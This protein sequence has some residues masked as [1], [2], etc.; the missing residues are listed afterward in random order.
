MERGTKCGHTWQ[1]TSRI[2]VKVQPV[3]VIASPARPAPT[4]EVA[5]RQSWLSGRPAAL[6]LAVALLAL[7]AATRLYDLRSLPIFFD[8]AHYTLSAL[9]I[10]RDPLHA[11][12]FTEVAHWGVPPLFT[13]L[14]APLAALL[15]DPLLGAR[16][17]SALIGLAG[18]LGVWLC[19][20]AVG[21]SIVAWVAAF[22][23]TICPFTLLYTRMAMVDGL[24]AVV[25]CYALILTIRLVRRPAPA[26]AYLLGLCGVAAVFTKIFGPLVLA[27]P[28]IAVVVATRSDRRLVSRQAARAA[29]IGLAGCAA[30]LATPGASSLILVAQQQ[31]AAKTSL[32]QH[33]AGQSG[34]IAQSLWLYLTP[35]ALLL[36]LIGLV[37]AWREMEIR[38]LALWALA[39]T[40]PFVY[41]HLSPRYLL[42]GA[43]PV[44]VLAA[45]GVEALLVQSHRQGGRGRASLSF[46]LA[47]S[48]ALATLAVCGW[49]DV[50]LI[51]APAQAAL[52]PADRHQY[53]TGWPAGYALQKALQAVR[54]Y[55]GGQSVT[56]IAAPQNPPADALAVVVANDPHIRVVFRDL[57]TLRHAG[58]LRGYATR[59]LV[60]TCPPYG[61]GLDTSQA[62]FRLIYVAR[63]LDGR[64]GVY[65]YAP[66]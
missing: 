57:A 56:L 5:P 64:G 15:S 28:A 2:E 50:S 1:G 21:G 26:T 41:V 29:L 55:A 16:L 36:A 4:L 44:L 31:Q 24:L 42:V 45:R 18:L 19:G 61:P 51:G 17:T 34:L 7:Y 25:S 46:V 48:L 33:L 8:E 30:L 3:G 9:V 39:C 38:L 63:N 40:L 60:V 20:R 10:G 11:D 58:A 35:P 52:V 14:A 47:G 22:L 54:R 59:T 12:L 49:E 37:A 53:I 62:P 66:R 6:A 32:L 23:Y 13:W 27:L 65:L 43:M